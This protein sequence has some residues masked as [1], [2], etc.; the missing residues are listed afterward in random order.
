MTD[1]QDHGFR[2]PGPT[3]DREAGLSLQTGG[4]RG[5]KVPFWR[6]G[7]IWKVGQWNSCPSVTGREN[8]WRNGSG[9]RTEGP[10]PK[11]LKWEVPDCLQI[12]SWILQRNWLSY[13]SSVGCAFLSVHHLLL[14]HEVVMACPHAHLPKLSCAPSLSKSTWRDSGVPSPPS[15][16]RR[17]GRIPHK[18]PSNGVLRSEVGHNFTCPM[19]CIL[20]WSWWWSWEAPCTLRPWEKICHSKSHLSWFFPVGSFLI[21]LGYTHLLLCKSQSGIFHSSPAKVQVK[22][23]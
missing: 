2:E 5:I 8:W 1:N 10:Q 22:K 13:R 14:L 6:P 7:D 18:E 21:Y 17:G 9:N 19:S 15:G 23:F 4:E 3:V 20:I 12:K 16:M 11:A